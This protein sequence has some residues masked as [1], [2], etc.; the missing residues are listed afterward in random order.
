MESTQMFA[1]H[2]VVLH[3]LIVLTPVGIREDEDA[4]LLGAADR[5]A[6]DAREARPTEQNG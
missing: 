4:L 2:L 6:A 5:P 1:F 3:V